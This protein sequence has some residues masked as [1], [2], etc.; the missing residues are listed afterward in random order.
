M[1]AFLCCHTGTRG[2][3]GTWCERSVSGRS[4]PVPT[5]AIS[6]Q[7]LTSNPTCFSTDPM[8][9]STSTMASVRASRPVSVRL[10]DLFGV[11]EWLHVCTRLYVHAC[12][13]VRVCVCACTGVRVWVDVKACACADLC[14]LAAVCL[15]GGGDELAGNLLFN[16]DRQTIYHGVINVWERMPYISDI[17]LVRNFSK[18]PFN[19]TTEMPT[20]EQLRDGYLPAFDLAPKGVPSI[21]VKGTIAVCHTMYHATF[22][23]SMRGTFVWSMRAH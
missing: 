8:Q 19:T 6:P 20:L 2:W 17:G 13:C 15:L 14:A 4:S 3:L 1:G 7:G 22:R 23:A 16:W 12:A 5:S 9:Q 18:A 11:C 21:V 10:L